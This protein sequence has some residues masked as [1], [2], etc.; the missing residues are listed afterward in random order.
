MK[1]T[2]KL[3][4]GVLTILVSLALVYFLVKYTSAIEFFSSPVS[5]RFVTLGTYRLTTTPITSSSPNGLI[6]ISRISTTP[7]NSDWANITHRITNDQ[8]YTYTD[9]T[10]RDM[11]GINVKALI[12]SI[13]TCKNIPEFSNHLGVNSRP[14]LIL[15]LQSSTPSRESFF[16]FRGPRDR[17]D[18]DPPVTPPPVIPPPVTPPPVIPPPVIPPPVI[19][20]PV[21]P[22][23]V[24]PPVTPPPVTP[25]PVTPAALSRMFFVKC[26]VPSANVAGSSTIVGEI[27]GN[28]IATY[29]SGGPQP[30]AVIQGGVGAPD[31]NATYTLSY[32]ICAA[33]NRPE[34]FSYSDCCSAINNTTPI[35]SYAISSS[36]YTSNCVST[37][38]KD[39]GDTCSGG[40]ECRS[41]TCRN[42]KC[43]AS[44]S[45]EG[46]SN[47]QSCSEKRD[48]A[49]GL[50][51]SNNICRV[52]RT[53]YC[54]RYPSGY[55]P[56]YGI[57]CSQQVGTY[58]ASDSK[59][60]EK[61]RWKNWD[62][63]TTD[64]DDDIY[65][66]DD[67]YRSSGRDKDR[68]R[69]TTEDDEEEIYD[70]EEWYRSKGRDKDRDSDGPRS[71]RASKMWR[72]WI[73]N[74]RGDPEKDSE[75]SSSWSG[76]GNRWRGSTK[77]MS[78]QLENIRPQR[79][80]HS[81]V[82]TKTMQPSLAI[83]NNFYN[84]KKASD[85]ADEESC[86]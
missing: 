25:P 4:W 78:D 67:W 77:D 56:D 64:D 28:T 34:G 26:F 63:G 10:P 76:I 69:E 54:N 39:T 33:G 65:N 23:P 41:G 1:P 40:T 2:S 52:Q 27:A 81:I 12:N 18:R 60:D 50:T 13:M 58:S 37:E 21:T 19:P 31:L 73:E 29:Y 59:D 43:V 74:S 22:P 6:Y 38:K 20:P 79:F 36:D 61:T 17:G 80:S 24:T 68:D 30:V 3:V 72:E 75:S 9:F 47:G 15:C 49:T 35:V 5:C 82:D 53:Y 62:W 48:C 86:E 85:T 45:S 11:N 14:A 84:C 55:D 83:C 44:S 8:S 32:T 16:N 71:D 70:P 42:S 66:A 46:K 7:V 57:P 51:C